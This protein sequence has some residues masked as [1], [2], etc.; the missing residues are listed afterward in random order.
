MGP[1]FRSTAHNLFRIPTDCTARGLIGDRRRRLIGEC[2]PHKDDVGDDVVDVEIEASVDD[3]ADDVADVKIKAS[4]DDVAD[5]VADVKIEASVDD[6]A[7]DVA[8]VKIKASVDDVADDE[9]DVEIE[10]GVDDVADD[11]VDVEI[12][13]SVDVV[14]NWIRISGGTT[15]LCVVEATTGTAVAV[16]TRTIVVPKT[17]KAPTRSASSANRALSFRSERVAPF[18]PPGT[19][20]APRLYRNWIHTHAFLAC[21]R[22]LRYRNSIDVHARDAREQNLLPPRMAFRRSGTAGP[23]APF[24]RHSGL[25]GFLARR[26][27]AA[28]CVRLPSA[29]HRNRSCRPRPTPHIDNTNKLVVE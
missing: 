18:S 16:S 6:V 11:E 27:R 28:V 9:V 29:T 13:A 15:A 23:V 4:V 8:D 12:E 19:A 14:D 2:S 3:V 26:S 25:P 20:T 7:D 5:D 17:A 22:P 24:G 10:A 1:Y 21:A